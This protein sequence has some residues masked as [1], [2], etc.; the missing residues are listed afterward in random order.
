MEIFF[1]FLT[2]KWTDTMDHFV[3]Y[4]KHDNPGDII[5]EAWNL[6]ID[7]ISSLTRKFEDKLVISGEVV[8]SL[9]IT[10][11]VFVYKRTLGNGN[12]KKK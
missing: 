12:T 7:L 3:S 8:K 2:H 6:L 5:N 11:H 1:E 4:T 9:K 10:Q